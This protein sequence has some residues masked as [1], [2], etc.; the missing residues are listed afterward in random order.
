MSDVL[1]DPIPEPEGDDVEVVDFSDQDIY[2]NMGVSDARWDRAKA[3]PDVRDLLSDLEGARGNPIS[4]PFHGSD[5]KPSFYIYPKAND[6]WC[7]GCG[8]VDGY[9]DNVKIVARHFGMATAEGKDDRVT[10]LK[11]LE[12]H[13]PMP[14]LKD[15]ESYRPPDMVIVDEE[16]SALPEDPLAQVDIKLLREHFVQLAAGRVRAQQQHPAQAVVVAQEH[17]ELLFDAL[18]QGNKLALARALGRTKMANLGWK[19]N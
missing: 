15:D 8:E 17:L 18:R 7:W 10:A 4:C 19:S 13:Y 9:W 1:D 6:C 16:A 12:A 2:L 11:W 3:N 14:E 5:S